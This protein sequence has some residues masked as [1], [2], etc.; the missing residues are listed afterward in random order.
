MTTKAQE[1]T[2]HLQRLLQRFLPDESL[3]VP[4]SVY[5]E[6]TRDGVLAI[7]R[8]GRPGEPEMTL[9]GFRSC[10]YSHEFAVEIY[11][12][13]VNPDERERFYADFVERIGLALESDPTLGG[14]VFG[15]T[16]GHAEMTT[17]PI[18]G[19]ADLKYGGIDLLIEYETAAPLA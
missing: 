7:L 5:A 6:Q 2:A 19:A 10:V 9:G 3:A 12:Q 15:F 18:E 16:Y 4:N 11:V 14:L 1:I 13:H 17:D 8:E